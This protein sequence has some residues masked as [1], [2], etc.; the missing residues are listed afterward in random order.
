MQTVAARLCSDL[1]AIT[2][3]IADLI[4]ELP[5]ER[6]DQYGSSIVFIVPDY[7]WGQAQY[8]TGIRH[9]RALAATQRPRTHMRLK[10]RGGL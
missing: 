9:S 10:E 5:I 3:R 8:S 4:R 1:E 6:F 2:D 7:Y